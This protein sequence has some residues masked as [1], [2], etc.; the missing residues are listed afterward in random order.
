LELEALEAS[1]ANYNQLITKNSTISLQLQQALVQ[2]QPEAFQMAKMIGTSLGSN[3]GSGNNPGDHLSNPGASNKG[4]S[5]SAGNPIEHH[6][7]QQAVLP[8]GP[9]VALRGKVSAIAAQPMAASVATVL[10]QNVVSA[11]LDNYHTIEGRVRY[12]MRERLKIEKAI[13]RIKWVAVEEPGVI[14][15]TLE[16]IR[17]ILERLRTEAQPRVEVLLDNVSAT[18]LETKGVLTNVNT[19]LES[20]QSAFDFLNQ[21]SLY[22]KIGLAVA[23]GLTLLIMLMGL[24]ALF[25]IAFGI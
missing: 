5:Y 4:G 13:Y 16:E 15:K 6:H 19:S 7:M 18:V 12:Y 3:G 11:Y 23:G 24:I 22:I 25:R 1:L 10:N 9:S 2:A 17:G 20:V 21:Y 8:S 14:P